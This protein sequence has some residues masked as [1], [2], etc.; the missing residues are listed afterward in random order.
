[1]ID[2]IA[3]SNRSRAFSKRI[4]GNADSRSKVMLLRLIH[5]LA[6]RRSRRSAIERR[7]SGLEILSI[8]DDAVAE[9]A[10]T[11]ATIPGARNLRSSRRTPE[12]GQEVYEEAIL[13]PWWSKV[14]IAHAQA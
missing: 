14:R 3:C 6:K 9:V 5:I 10:G 1:M 8:H 12:A 4:P 11:S 7:R 13:I 2:A